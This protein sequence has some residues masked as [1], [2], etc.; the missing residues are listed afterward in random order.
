MQ[1]DDLC[2]GFSDQPGISQYKLEVIPSL[3]SSP[4]PEENIWREPKWKG[5]T[6]TSQAVR[7]QLKRWT[8]PA[9]LLK[10][11]SLNPEELL[12]TYPKSQKSQLALRRTAHTSLRASGPILMPISSQYKKKWA[13]TKD[14]SASHVFQGQHQLIPASSNYLHINS[15]WL[16]TW[17]F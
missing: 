16:Q 17:D 3:H 12:Y 8:E 7:A 1:L 14:Y 9:T 11:K 5:G 4:C 6:R 13:N 10:Q 15:V 2:Y